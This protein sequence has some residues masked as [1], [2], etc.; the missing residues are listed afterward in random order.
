MQGRIPDGREKNGKKKIKESGQ[1]LFGF[2]TSYVA[3]ISGPVSQIVQTLT[4]E[5]FKTRVAHYFY[6]GFS[7]RM[8]FI[9]EARNLVKPRNFARFD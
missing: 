5:F 1:V 7:P 2:I 8:I 6:T 9:D 4:V 3:Y